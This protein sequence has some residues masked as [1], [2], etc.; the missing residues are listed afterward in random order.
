[1]QQQIRLKELKHSPNNVR[2]VKAS[3]DSHW[4][5]VASIKSK[6]LLHN[7]VVVKNGNGFNVIDGNR[8]LDAL[9][10]IYKD[11]ATP[12][13]CVVLESDDSEVGLHANMMREDMHPLDECDVI[14]AL[15]SDGSETYDSVGKRFGQTDRWVKQRVGLAELS[16]KAK[17]MF[18]N[19]EFNIGV[20]EALTLG[21]HER[22][23][24]Y[25][26]ENTHFHLA[27]VKHF[28]TAKKI[29][30]EHALFKI[31]DSNR[32]DLV[33]EQDLFGDQEWITNVEE[34]NRLQDKALLD[35]VDAYRDAGYSDVILLRDSFHWDDPACRG[36]T[37]VYDE[38]HETYSIADKILCIAYNSSRFDVQTTE[39]VLRETKEQQEAQEMEEEIEKEVTPLTMSKPQEALLAGYFAHFM[40]DSMFSE[41]LTYVNF[42]KAM[43]CHRSLGYTYSNT[44]RVGHIYADHQ[45]IFPSEEYPD[46]YVHPRHEGCIQRHIDA[47]RNAFDTDGTTPLMYCISLPDTELDELFVACCLTGL[48]K[49]DF[50]SDTLKEVLPDYAA[51]SKGWFKPDAK[52]LNKYKINQI[53]MLEDY[54]FGKVSS[55]P[56][57][58]RIDALVKFLA[59]NP[60][61]D[62]LGD[63]PQ[64]KPQ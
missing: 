30:T 8:R 21:N 50:Y 25:L 7:L 9:N 43:L 58:P 53:E 15:V 2:Q 38:K 55:G 40:K 24:K 39:L 10:Q 44:N 32:A 28:M 59:D 29:E 41:E 16:D 45:T 64:Y 63:W 60:V 27:S 19:G 35:L 51:R 23:D 48:G 37:A 42:M 1:M 46:D 47:A 22:Q 12:V 18:R 13:N 14:M 5:L 62:P 34:F 52:W 57:K 36:F 33:I 54:C 4:Q 6:G 17:Q 56:K 31:N 20:A 61:F 11:K 49:Y 3:K 26:E